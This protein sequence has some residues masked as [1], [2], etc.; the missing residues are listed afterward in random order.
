MSITHT[1]TAEEIA[2]RERLAEL[3]REIAKLVLIRLRVKA[4]YRMNHSSAEFG[5]AKAAYRQEVGIPTFYD[6]MPDRWHMK[7]A[8]TAM[9]I[10]S[11][12]LR[13]KVHGQPRPHSN[14]V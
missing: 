6:D 13:G 1:L 10:E 7:S 5:Q 11:A 9:H 14:P 2:K 4:I 12:T 8:I 3:K